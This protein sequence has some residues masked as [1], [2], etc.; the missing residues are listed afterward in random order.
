MLISTVVAVALGVAPVNPDN[1]VIAGDY[2]SQIGRYSQF[3]D[4]RGTTHLRG[5]DARGVSY[6]LVMDRNGF[7][8]ASVGDRVVSFRVKQ[9]A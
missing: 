1:Q 6:D 7:V 8:E 4:R 3:V 2:S 9:Q 5:R